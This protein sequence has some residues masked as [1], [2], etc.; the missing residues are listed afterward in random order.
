MTESE[1]FQLW[2]IFIVN[3]DSIN[4]SDFPL[5]SVVIPTF[6]RPHYLKRCIDSILNQD[7]SPLEVIVVDDNDPNT[8]SREE[9]QEIMKLYSKNDN[10]LY[11]KHPYN[12]NGSAARNTGWKHAKGEYITFIDDDDVISQNK[13]KKQVEALE[14]L[15][16]SWGCC[17]T[18]YKLIKPDGQTQLSSESRSGNCYIE[19]LMRTFFLGSGSN[20]LLRKKVVDEICG[21]DESFKRNQDIEFLVRVLEKY[22]IAFIDEELLTIYQDSDRT[23][24]K[25]FN[26]LDSYALHYLETF[27]SRINRLNEAD[28]ERV[29]AVISLERCRI[30]FYKKEYGAGLR[31]LKSNNV[32]L[33][34]IA[35]YIKYLANRLVTNES[36]GF[37]GLNKRK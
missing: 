25:S 26:L 5:V 7:Y 24:N 28:R 31:I 34:F 35:R 4:Q 29:L 2:R 20:L 19:A 15:D 27:N 21:Y 23:K 36:Y 32:K 22:K 37:D 30:A 6:S 14:Q 9:T 12:K 8:S 3:G 33:K 16:E 1:F 13:I 11:L 18:K 17:Y 10:V